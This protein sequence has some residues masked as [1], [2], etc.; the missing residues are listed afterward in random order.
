MLIW[1]CVCGF[2][3]D[4]LFLIVKCSYL[5]GGEILLVYC[6]VFCGILS[7]FFDVFGLMVLVSVRNVGMNCVVLGVRVF[8]VDYEDFIDDM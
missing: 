2:I 6:M 3:F 8:W 7:L 4:D 5:F 1:W